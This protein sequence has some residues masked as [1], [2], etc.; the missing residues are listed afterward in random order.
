MF[1][2]KRLILTISK[3]NR[4]FSLRQRATPLHFTEMPDAKW[5]NTWSNGNSGSSILICSIAST[6]GGGPNPIHEGLCDAIGC[7]IHRSLLPSSSYCPSLSSLQIL[8]SSDASG[9]LQFYLS[10]RVLP[11]M[12]VICLCIY[13]LFLHVWSARKR[14][15]E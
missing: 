3:H 7:S 4:P 1:F 5:V 2:K 15:K 9:L 6:G 8:F 11:Q 10:G 13:L 12:S 14:R